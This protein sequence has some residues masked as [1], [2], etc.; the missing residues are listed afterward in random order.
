MIETTMKPP[1]DFLSS[2]SLMGYIMLGCGRAAAP[3]VSR[4]DATMV[5]IVG[6]QADDVVLDISQ[7]DASIDI[8]SV[9]D[10][11]TDVVTD[12]PS[13][14]PNDAGPCDPRRVRAANSGS[15]CWP[16]HPDE[17]RADCPSPSGA[18]CQLGVCC[19]GEID[20]V[21]CDCRC[22]GTSPCDETASGRRENCCFA[23]EH[24]DPNDPRD[25]QEPF[26]CS[27]SCD[28]LKS[29]TGSIGP[30]GEIDENQSDDYKHC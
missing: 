23:S 30:Q 5:D 20:P 17:P 11:P 22:P 8:P 15:V 2:S 21:T 1:T 29:D 9:R 25:V 18:V 6:D 26:I 4:Y 28:S 19:S 12:Q 16:R 10:V 24:R 14:D 27:H 7:Q 3:D 13:F